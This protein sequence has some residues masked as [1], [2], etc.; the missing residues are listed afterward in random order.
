MTKTIDWLLT[1]RE[2]WCIQVAGGEAKPTLLYYQYDE[3]SHSVM[4][5]G[6]SILK[7][8]LFH[9]QAN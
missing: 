1:S 3:W 4:L 2:N 7:A 9:G 6:N 8:I 5:P